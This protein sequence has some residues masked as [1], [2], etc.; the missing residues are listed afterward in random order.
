MNIQG[1]YFEGGNMKQKVHA[2]KKKK[3]IG[4]KQ[5]TISLSSNG[6]LLHGGG[7]GGG[8][9]GEDVDGDKNVAG[10]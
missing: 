3:I 6:K 7:G 1:H 8:G 10:V 5:T 9:V 4:P 2:P